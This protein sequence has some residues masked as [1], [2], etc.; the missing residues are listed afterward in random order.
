MLDVLTIFGL[1]SSLLCL[2]LVVVLIFKANHN[3]P[4]NNINQ[5]VELKTQNEYLEKMIKNSFESAAASNKQMNELFL[6]TIKEYN[7]SVSNFLSNLSKSQ[8]QQL[9]NIEVRLNEILRDNDAKL[10]RIA[11]VIS[12]NLQTLQENNEKKLE[13][14]RQTVDEKLYATLEQRVGESVKVIVQGLDTVSKSVGE[15]QVLA[16]GVGDLKRVL[17]NVKTRGGWG[18]VQLSQMLQI[19][20]LVVKERHQLMPINIMFV[21]Q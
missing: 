13:Q 3:S 6:T 17:T 10:R 16:N 2:G 5:L 12:S 9:L 11:D 14:M 1:I 21:Q 15:M 19:V 7:D 8:G 20:G 18:E 4:T